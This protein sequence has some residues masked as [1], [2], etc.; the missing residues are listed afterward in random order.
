MKKI[1][2]LIAAVIALNA[3]RIESRADHSAHPEVGEL[4]TIG[5][6]TVLADI[7]WSPPKCAF[8]F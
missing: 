5:R 1:I 8:V 6:K 4:T 3:F 7:V 2:T